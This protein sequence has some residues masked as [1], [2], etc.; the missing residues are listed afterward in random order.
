MYHIYQFVFQLLLSACLYGVYSFIRRKKIRSSTHIVVLLLFVNLPYLV[1]NI[2]NPVYDGPAFTHLSD[3]R[4]PIQGDRVRNWGDTITC[5]PKV[6]LQPTSVEEIQ[7]I[8]LNNDK[9][10][11]VGGGHS[12]SPLICTEYTMI[13][14]SKMDKILNLTDTTVTCE[15]GSSLKYLIT[16][17][18]ETDKIIHGFGSIQDQSLAGAFSTSH[19]GLTFHSFAEDVVSITAVLS[20]GTVTHT[21]D[22]YYWRSHLGLLGIITS[23]TINTYQNSKVK[24]KKNKISIEDA[25]NLLPSADAGI[26]ETNYNQR[27]QGL[28]K[29]ITI[30][31]NANNEKYPIKTDD[32]ISAIWDSI[33]IP[34]VVLFPSLSKF[35]LLD[36]VE[37]DDVSEKPMV[38]AWSKFPEYGM[39]YSAYA[40]PFQNCSN[41]ISSINGEQHDISTILVRYVHGQ[42]NTTCLTFARKES[43]VVDIYDLQSQDTL[44]DF[45]ISIESLANQF[46]GTSHWG[47]YYVGDIKKQV[48]HIQCYESF[49]VYREMVDP[50]QKFV[51]DYTK[52][53]LNLSNTKRYK[54]SHYQTKRIGYL[55]VTATSFIVV[56]SVLVIGCVEQNDYELL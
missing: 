55:V 18:L 20:N 29:Y 53:I 48:E 2:F 13:S 35:P 14:L 6:I 4:S 16:R 46:G 51:N 56:I 47:K 43:C 44:H 12:F 39:M 54:V 38:E 36:I 52:E 24:I 5:K 21:N 15:A 17:L 27:D 32:F 9:I 19:H 31:G 11:V 42:E 30:V 22:L 34:T 37:T 50:E 49:K 7:E 3:N 25:I 23:M 26:I 28:L 33:I 10:R 8:V 40:I 41:F 1:Y 45:H